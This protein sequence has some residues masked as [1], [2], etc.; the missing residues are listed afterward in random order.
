MSNSARA[1]VMLV[2]R[3]E[4]E[5]EYSDLNLLCIDGM[6][7]AIIGIAQQFNTISV[8]YDRNKCI[9]IL[10]KDMTHLE[11]VEYFEYNIVGAY[12]GE[13]TPTFIDL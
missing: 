7:K 6:D 13:H 5:E 8:A 11:A 2:T 4:I 3:K 12:T 9:K 10:M 1:G